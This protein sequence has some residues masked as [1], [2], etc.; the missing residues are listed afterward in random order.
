MANVLVVSLMD[1]HTQRWKVVEL[2]WS[3]NIRVHMENWRHPVCGRFPCISRMLGRAPCTILLYY[4]VDL[5]YSCV[6]CIAMCC[7]LSFFKKTTTRRGRTMLCFAHSKL[8]HTKLLF[9]FI[10]FFYRLHVPAHLSL[11]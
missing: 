7:T 1:T 10:S 2:V 11:F 6:A 4:T 8:I 3:Y 5:K 9:T